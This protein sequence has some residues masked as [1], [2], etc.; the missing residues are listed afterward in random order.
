MEAEEMKDVQLTREKVRRKI[1]KLRSDAVAGPDGI[2]PRL[3]QELLE[4]VVGG[5]SL[6][7]QK[8]FESGS[9]PGDWKDTNVIL[10]FKKGAKWDPGITDRFP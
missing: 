1:Q 3:L 2:G 5:L 7:F 6:T 10:I 9:V 4:E 8:S